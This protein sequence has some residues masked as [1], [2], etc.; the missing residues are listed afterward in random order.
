MNS[1]LLQYCSTFQSFFIRYGSTPVPGS[2]LVSY[3][4]SVLLTT[5]VF[6]SHTRG[7]ALYFHVAPPHRGHDDSLIF[8]NVVEWI[9]RHTCRFLFDTPRNA[10][11]P[12]DANECEQILLHVCVQ[13]YSRKYYISMDVV[14][15]CTCVC[16]QRILATKRCHQTVI[17]HIICSNVVES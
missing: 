10:T 12:I 13:L 6:M 17:V 9:R 16:I 8:H 7:P 2:T 1:E 5:V 11:P 3:S 4:T 14:Y 15:L